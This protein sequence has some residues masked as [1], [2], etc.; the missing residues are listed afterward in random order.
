MYRFLV[1]LDEDTTCTICMETFDLV[2]RQPKLLPCNHTFC[3]HCILKLVDNAFSDTFKC[4]LCNSSMCRQ[5]NRTSNLPNN[6]AVL[7]LLEKLTALSKELGA[8]R[9]TAK[10]PIDCDCETTSM[11]CNQCIVTLLQM[12]AIHIQEVLSHIHF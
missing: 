7:S 10:T 1:D 12:D 5:Q 8:I 6:L 9:A 4:P 2:D 11:M 3:C